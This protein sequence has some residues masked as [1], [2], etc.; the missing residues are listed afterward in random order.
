MSDQPR[1]GNTKW[2]TDLDNDSTSGPFKEAFK[3]QRLSIFLDVF[4]A[5]RHFSRDD[6]YQMAPWFTTFL[7]FH[8]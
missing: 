7:D 3:S 5:V 8:D 6:W 2:G 4:D 1:L